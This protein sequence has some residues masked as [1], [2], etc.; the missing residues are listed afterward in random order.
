M[1]SDYM[2][3]RVHILRMAGATNSELDSCADALQT[4]MDQLDS[5]SAR[6][7]VMRRALGITPEQMNA[8][9]EAEK[10]DPL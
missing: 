5:C 6:V 2:K 3:S 7:R 4:M 8:M 10:I 9:V 1:A